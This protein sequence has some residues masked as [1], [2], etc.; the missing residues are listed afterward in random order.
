MNKYDSII[1]K[2][3]IKSDKYPHMSLYNRA[4][5]FHPFA[6]LTGFE[7]EVIETSRLTDKN[8]DKYEDM[9]NKLDESI[10]YLNTNLDKKI[11]VSFTYFIKDKYKEGGKYIKINGVIR[12]IDTVNKKIVLTDKTILEFDNIID[13]KY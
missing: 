3:Y 5:Q 11:N 4:C 6:A 10:N 9:N 2:P 1:N 8:V 12:V 7:E 13:I